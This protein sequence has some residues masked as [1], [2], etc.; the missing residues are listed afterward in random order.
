[1]AKEIPSLLKIAQKARK[2][3]EE[4]TV[5][6]DRLEDLYRTYQPEVLDIGLFV[7]SAQR[8]FPNLNCG[9][10]SVYLQAEIGLGEIIQGFFN[11][12]PHT[13]LAINDTIID[14]TADQYGGP[15]IYVGPLVGQWSRKWNQPN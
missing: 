11:D 15:P 10:A 6:R 3:F 9:L 13:F 4:R 7:E 1:M 2:S 14:I 5:S 8:L 12:A